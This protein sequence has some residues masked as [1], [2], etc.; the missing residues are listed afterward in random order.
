MELIEI[1]NNLIKLSYTEEEK[2]TLGHFIAL[3]S[4]DKSYVA[5][6]VNLKAD[7]M[8]NFAVARLMFTFNS[9]AR[10]KRV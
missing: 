9:E 4:G 8:N 2:P 6:Y 10:C 1:R 7:N 3:T 5:Q